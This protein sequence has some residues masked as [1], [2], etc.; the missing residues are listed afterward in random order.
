MNK[1][2][3]GLQPGTNVPSPLGATS[4][5][6]TAV[7]SGSMIIALLLYSAHA[8]TASQLGYDAMLRHIVGYGGWIGPVMI[9]PSDLGH[10]YGC[11]TTR[12]IE[13]DELL[14]IVP[15]K[16]QISAP[17]AFL[18]N[19][20]GA[21]FANE[22][23]T[24]MTAIAG[25]MAM[26]A[27]CGSAEHTPYLSTL[28][29]SPDE[30]H[31]LWWSDREIALLA[32]T[33]AHDEAT[34]IRDQADE[35]VASALRNHPL[36]EAVALSLQ[37]S[38]SDGEVD[39]RLS[40]SVR[41][42]CSCILSR[43]FGT[44]DGGSEMV[45]ILDMLQH[46]GGEHSVSYSDEVMDAVFETATKAECDLIHAT[47]NHASLCCEVRA[48]R[49]LSKGTELTTDYGAHPD[50]VFGSHYSFSTA[51]DAAHAAYATADDGQARAQALESL[52]T[53]AAGLRI[54]EIAMEMAAES[55]P[56]LAPASRGIEVAL[57]AQRAAEYMDSDTAVRAWNSMRKR[58]RRPRRHTAGGAPI[59]PFHALSTLLAATGAC[60]SSPLRFVVTSSTISEAIS[61]AATSG[62]RPKRGGASLDAML[63]CARL[64]VLDEADLRSMD[65]PS[66]VVAAG[67]D[68]QEQPELHPEPPGL[69]EPLGDDEAERLMT[70]ALKRLT[71]SRSGQISTA[72]DQRAAALLHATASRQLEVLDS[73]TPDAAIGDVRPECLS[74]ALSLRRSERFVL[75]RMQ[76]SASELFAQ[77]GPDVWF[78]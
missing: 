19:V 13:D 50:F 72:N 60:A 61:D 2:A 24:A 1:V 73:A 32:G 30:P 70:L 69:A 35:A 77:G 42:A 65:M 39:E 21:T 71:G 45:P 23:A 37:E 59:D 3:P 38:E 26:S 18:D 43:A 62:D 10:G 48:N 78:P 11:Y 67:G 29:L 12:D 76:E 41:A 52:G 25:F 31:I 46:G 40:E 4:R 57:S 58:G 55:A 44:A 27:L 15:A 75:V 9:R 56:V 66:E 5:T 28:P 64:C 16:V 63:S 6:A 47:P 74:L 54:E 49:R 8:A 68:E 33:S 36:R 34:Q 51:D 53:C 14:F 22:D 17:T 20:C 7:V